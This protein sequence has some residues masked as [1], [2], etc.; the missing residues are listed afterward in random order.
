MKVLF[1]KS[2]YDNLLQFIQRLLKYKKKKKNIFFDYNFFS[3]F[4]NMTTD[5]I[6]NYF[7]QSSFT[8][9]KS[10]QNIDNEIIHNDLV[11]RLIEPKFISVSIN[12]KIDEKIIEGEKK[13]GNVGEQL[14]TK[15]IASDIKDWGKILWENRDNIEPLKKKRNK[16]FSFK[17]KKSFKNIFK[18]FLKIN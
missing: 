4:K 18:K 15:L 7:K 13:V 14:I 16:K 17:G 12:K 2:K 5:Q 8:V 11:L 6:D 1:Y 10:E 3:S 9:I